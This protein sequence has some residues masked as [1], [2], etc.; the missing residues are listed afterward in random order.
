MKQEETDTDTWHRIERQCG[1]FLQRFKFP[2]NANME[3][4][5]CMLDHGVLTVTVPKKETGKLQE[6]SGLSRAVDIN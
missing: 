1:S 4:V 2:E 5:Q 3:D 6:T